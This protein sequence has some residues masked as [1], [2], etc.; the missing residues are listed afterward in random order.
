MKENFDVE[1]MLQIRSSLADLPRTAQ[2][3]AR[4]PKRG[5]FPASLIGE[6][7]QTHLASRLAGPPRQLSLTPH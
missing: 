3:F 5:C 4:S 1:K 7:M 6:V 2:L